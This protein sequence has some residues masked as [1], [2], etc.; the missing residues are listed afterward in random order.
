MVHTRISRR[1]NGNLSF[2]LTMTSRLVSW[3]RRKPCQVSVE[4][5]WQLASHWHLLHIACQP[6]TS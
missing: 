5:V 1:H 4:R 2:C 3:S 6:C